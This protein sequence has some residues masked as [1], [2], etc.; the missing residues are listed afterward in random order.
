MRNQFHAFL[1][2]IAKIL[3]SIEAA[4]LVWFIARR[5]EYH[6]QRARA[7]TIAPGFTI[8]P[9]A[10]YHTLEALAADLPYLSLS[11]I[12]RYI[13]AIAKAK[14][15]HVSKHNPRLAFDRQHRFSLSGHYQPHH[16]AP[17]EGTYK[18]WV[19]HAVQY[20]V[21][22]AVII[23]HIQSLALS[24]EQH[25]RRCA[26]DQQGRVYV[27]IQPGFYA[28]KLGL[29][30]KT[31]ARLLDSLVPRKDR[32]G[33]QQPG[34]MLEARIG[35]GASYYAVHPDLANGGIVAPERMFLINPA[36][37]V[38]TPL[39]KGRNKRQKPVLHREQMGG[40]F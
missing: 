15:L 29:N 13:A 12:R 28:E 7:V 27:R 3:G 23:N 18:F 39:R 11:S 9:W 10:F 17:E 24:P 2:R 14:V 35:K 36:G 22:P 21:S 1:P 20:G 25:P 31:I 6:E 33:N 16:L 30:R 40:T 8:K 32:Q 19:A 5:G 38:L 37:T 34:V 4:A 26:K